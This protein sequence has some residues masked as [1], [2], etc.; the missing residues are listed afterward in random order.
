[1]N[2]PSSRNVR[3]MIWHGI[4]SFSPDVSRLEAASTP[5]SCS[6]LESDARLYTSQGI[7]STRASCHSD[8]EN[9]L[10]GAS[11][12]GCESEIVM[13][14]PSAT[15]GSGS[16]TLKSQASINSKSLRCD[17]ASHEFPCKRKTQCSEN[18]GTSH[19]SFVATSPEFVSRWIRRDLFVAE[20]T[21]NTPNS[22]IQ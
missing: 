20:L 8:F 6:N 13:S 12:G 19:P 4:F 14:F 22:A 2:E 3:I 9:H 10:S 21:I 11:I 5:S 1:V 17:L 16:V 15:A 7:Q 18:R